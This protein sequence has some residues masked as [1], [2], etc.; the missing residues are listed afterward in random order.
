MNL[1]QQNQLKQAFLDDQLDAHE[2]DALLASLDGFEKEQLMKERD[3]NL[4][5]TSILSTNTLNC[6][7][8]V[9]EKTKSSFLPKNIAPVNNALLTWN[10][11][12]PTLAKTAA[13]L[14]FAFFLYFT[15]KEPSGIQLDPKLL[16]ASIQGD[17]HLI[18]AALA[19]QGIDLNISS[20]PKSHHSIRLVGMEWV[21]A[22]NQTPI[23]RVLFYC[24]EFPV[25]MFI[26]KNVGDQNSY[27]LE[28]EYSKLIHHLRKGNERYQI[29]AYSNHPPKEVL[30]LIF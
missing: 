11:A 22:K 4:G 16:T 19:A 15:M 24:C 27:H 20:E 25:I 3:F 13:V 12:I 17:H 6:P 9:W 28:A 10:Q 21:Q 5:L 18:H 2:S 7:N 14:A 26:K 30:D 23:A 8:E 29:D 1:D